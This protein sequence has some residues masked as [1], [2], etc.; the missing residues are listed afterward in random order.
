MKATCLFLFRDILRGTTN[1]QEK[2]ALHS[3]LCNATNTAIRKKW[4]PDHFSVSGGPKTVSSQGFKSRFCLWGAK[5]S[6]RKH[7]LTTHF[8]ADRD[9]GLHFVL[10]LG[11][12]TVLSIFEFRG[13]CIYR[14][15]LVVSVTH[16]AAELCAVFPSFFCCDASGERKKGYKK[17]QWRMLGKSRGEDAPRFRKT[18]R[19]SRQNASARTT[20]RA[21]LTIVPLS[22]KRK[23]GL[24]QR[25]TAP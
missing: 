23:W 12:A 14:G 24:Q 22:A 20:V 1:P 2:F 5:Q 13:C 3:T 15:I 8:H 11:F 16:S 4:T 9:G 18:T 10:H 19:I 6:S 17:Y 21:Y 7:L 25:A